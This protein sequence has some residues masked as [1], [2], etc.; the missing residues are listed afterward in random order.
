MYFL[1]CLPVICLWL[2]V[3]LLHNKITYIYTVLSVI[4]LTAVDSAHKQIK[5]WI[6]IIITTTTTT[7][8]GGS[9]T[10]SSKY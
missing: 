5:N 4:G 2:Y 1:Q 9:N 6:I 10:S 3:V 8:G 7:G